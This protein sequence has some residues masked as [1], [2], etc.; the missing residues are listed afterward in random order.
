[1]KTYI[2]NLA[3]N[4]SV[5]PIAAHLSNFNV[6]YLSPFLRANGICYYPLK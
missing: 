5:S 4:Y 3:A 2:L 1:M 6:N